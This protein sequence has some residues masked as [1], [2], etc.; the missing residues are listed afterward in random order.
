MV[1][2]PRA[3][4]LGKEIVKE[5]VEEAGKIVKKGKTKKAE[6][7]LEKKPIPVKIGDKKEVVVEGAETVT[8]ITDIRKNDG[9]AC[10]LSYIY[11]D[12]EAKN[13][14]SGPACK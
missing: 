5:V 10:N 8:T 1:I 11:E 12:G 2:S 6:T 9:T 3:I 13:T 4:T 14:K 7:L